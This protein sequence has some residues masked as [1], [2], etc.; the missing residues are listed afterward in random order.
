MVRRARKS[1]SRVRCAVNS[2]QAYCKVN[3]NFTAAQLIGQHRLGSNFADALLIDIPICH[4][5]GCGRHDVHCPMRAM[6]ATA[7]ED[8]RDGVQVSHMNIYV[9]PL[10]ISHYRVHMTTSISLLSIADCIGRVACGGYCCAT[11]FAS[12]IRSASK[13]YYDENQEEANARSK[14][15]VSSDR[16][17][18]Y[19]YK[20]TYYLR[21]GADVRR[22]T[23]VLIDQRRQ[24]RPSVVHELDVLDLSQFSETM[25]VLLLRI[26]WHS[27]K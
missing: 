16:A 21:S 13:R 25:G 23:T 12:R 1:R 22:Q 10:I 7:V 15:G 3:E 2:C 5:H 24:S 18:H 19:G 20:Q 8:V 11:S 14:A 6:R 26:C 4:K 27:L 9:P 17:R